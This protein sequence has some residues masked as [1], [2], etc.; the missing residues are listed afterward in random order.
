MTCRLLSLMLLFALAPLGAAAEE[1][2]LFRL[3]APGALAETGLLDHILPRFSLKTQVRVERVADPAEADLRLGDAGRPVFEGASGVWKMELTS[4]DADAARFADWLT[5][6]VGQRT[7]LSFA[8]QGTAL[9]RAPR[10]AAA[11]EEEFL[12]E[13]DVALGLEVSRDKCTRCHAVDEASRMAGIGST[14]SFGILRALP[15][16]DQRFAAFYV[17]NPH[18]AFMIIDGVTEPF[19][20]QRPSPISP[21]E[22]TL[23]EV[24]AMLAYVSAMP[25]KDLGA[26]IQHQ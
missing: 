16:W 24:E 7:V 20:E 5:G 17:L 25:P 9:F 15:D 8:P 1:D 4:D 26:P 2:R 12:F 14:P 22:M 3:H 13:G 11:A 21:I 6:D 23:D 10:V 18:P 19:S